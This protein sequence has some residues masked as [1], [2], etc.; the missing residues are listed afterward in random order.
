MWKIITKDRRKVRLLWW[1]P[2]WAPAVQKG[3]TGKNPAIS[4]GKLHGDHQRRSRGRGCAGGAVRPGK[5]D[6][7][8]EN[9]ARL[10]G[11]RQKRAALLRDTAIVRQAD[12][13][14]AFWDFKSRGTSSPSRIASA[15]ACR[16]GLSGLTIKNKNRKKVKFCNLSVAQRRKNQDENSRAERGQLLDEVQALRHER[17]KR[18]AEGNCQR[19]GLADSE[20][21]YV[22]GGKS[23][24]SSSSWPTTDRPCKRRWSCS[25]RAKQR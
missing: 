19:L 11:I 1:S 2:L 10:R 4:A 18:A 24:C 5:R 25:P 15:S 16:C 6:S 22:C 14:L 13:V 17:E 12:S 23:S 20:I 3:L 7:V 21:K 8:P 9:P